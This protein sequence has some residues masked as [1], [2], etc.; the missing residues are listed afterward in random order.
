ML[1][2]LIIL[3]LLFSLKAEMGNT[4][5]SE[6]ERNNVQG[7]VIEESDM[8]T[9]DFHNDTV[10][11]ILISIGIVVAMAIMFY[12]YQ[13]YKQRGKLARPMIVARRLQEL[14]AQHH[15]NIQ[16]AQQPSP[17]GG[18][19]ITPTPSIFTKTGEYAPYPSLSTPA[20]RTATTPPALTE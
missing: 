15:A 8:T 13:M 12:F 17:Y 2:S 5:S 7:L 9:L 18:V 14:E 19:K 20:L 16:M 6:P 4:A 11:Y 1:G 3:P 10:T